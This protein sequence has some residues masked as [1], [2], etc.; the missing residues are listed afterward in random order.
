MPPTTS[1]TMSTSSRVD[2]R[3]GVG[4]E[5]RWIDRQVARTLRPTHRDA[6]QLQRRPDPGGE[7]VVRAL[8]EQPDDLAAD[9]AA[10]RAARPAVRPSCRAHSAAERLQPA[11]SRAGRLRSRGGRSRARRRRAR[12]P[13]AAAAHGCSCWPST[14]GR[15]RSP[16]P[17]PGRPGARSAGIGTSWTT[18]IA[19]LAVL[20]DHRH[21]VR[22]A[23]LRSARPEP[24]C[25][26]RRT[27]RGG[28]CRSCRRRR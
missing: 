23:S 22:G 5:Q 4:G 9:D 27:A 18:T 21:H 26:A 10:A 14:G 15:R 8:I 3:R 19:A 11:S 28:C 16:A 25:S 1:T 6:D 24:P 13:P 2:Q 20:A 12:R 7:V 17:R